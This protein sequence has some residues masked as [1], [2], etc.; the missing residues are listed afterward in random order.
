MLRSV[1]WWSVI[2]V[3]VQPVFPIFKGQGDQED[4]YSKSFEN[5]LVPKTKL[6]LD[7]FDPTTNLIFL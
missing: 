5:I 1:D 4:L 3:S 7:A 2:D 6:R